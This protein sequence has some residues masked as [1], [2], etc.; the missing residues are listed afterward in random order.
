M[1]D[2]VYK[3]ISDCVV[4]SFMLQRQQLERHQGRRLLEAPVGNTST[5]AFYNVTY[6]GNLTLYAYLTSVSICTI[7][8]FDK[9]NP[10]TFCPVN[11]T[12]DS[13]GLASSVMTAA[14][15]A[16]RT[17]RLVRAPVPVYSSVCCP[18]VHLMLAAS[19]LQRG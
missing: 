8:T 16:N 19:S 10:P 4:L 3:P 14:M 6:N 18:R 5:G 12:I 2:L 9:N 13:K 1:V 7:S 15:D 17:V 11:F